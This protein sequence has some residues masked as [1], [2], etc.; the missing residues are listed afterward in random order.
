VNCYIVTDDAAEAVIID[1]GG[2][3]KKILNVVKERD[4]SVE[5]IVN[6]HA[7]FDHILSVEEVRAETGAGFLLHRE[8]SR[9]LDRA[10]EMS[11]IWMDYEI[12]YPEVTGYLEDG[13]VVQV[14][15]LRLEVLHTPGHT[16][17][18]ISLL[19]VDAVFTGDTLFA[20][21]VGRTDMPGGSWDRLMES[22]RT[23]LLRLEDSVRV[24][25]GHGPTTTIGKERRNNPFVRR[26][27]RSPD[28]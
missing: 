19:H 25:P 7:H 27:L 15:D 28:D 3:A 1:P 4:A 22:I 5:Y 21:G 8:E 13:D 24:Y 11:G 16:P 10:K 18:G 17:G 26:I 14:G 23:K 6:T 2:D 20:G 9:V 12:K